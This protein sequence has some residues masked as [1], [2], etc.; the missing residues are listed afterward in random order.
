MVSAQVCSKDQHRPEPRSASVFCTPAEK[1]RR[2]RTA[3]PAIASNKTSR[4]NARH[5]A[6]IQTNAETGKAA[7]AE[8]YLNRSS[9]ITTL[10]SLTT[11][12]GM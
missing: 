2:K 7:K 8:I 4:T 3:T 12:E 6:P 11:S 5:S 10:W 1:R 9:A